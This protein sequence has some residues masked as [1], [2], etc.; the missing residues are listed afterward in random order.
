[1]RQNPDN[2]INSRTLTPGELLTRYETIAEGLVQGQTY[3][4]IA[5]NLGVD[6]K[7]LQ[8]DRKEVGYQ[9]FIAPILDRSL[10][11]IEKLEKD[12]NEPA[13]LQGYLTILRIGSPRESR[14]ELSGPKQGPIRLD[15]SGLTDEERATLRELVKKAQPK[16]T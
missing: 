3:Q 8:R 14:V 4:K 16:T 13:A 7:T 12:K 5:K 10:K 11:L 9:Y 1:M 2:P 6:V 15:L